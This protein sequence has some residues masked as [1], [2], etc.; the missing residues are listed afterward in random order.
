M[1]RKIRKAIFPVAGM[2]TRF[3]PA[4]KSIP[5][6]MLTVVD[7]P[8]IQYAVDE[9]V[10]AGCDTLIFVTG[11]SKRAIEDYFDSSPE[12]EWELSQK[13]KQVALEAVRSII[14]AHVQCIY[15]RQ[16]MP[17]GLGHAVLCAASLIDKDEAFAVLLPDDL[18]D[19]QG[20]GVLGQM[21]DQWPVDAAGMIAVE[22][23]PEH[24][25]SK[26]GILRPSTSSPSSLI[27]IAS[28]VEKPSP[29]QAPS[30][31]AVVGRYILTQPV[32]QALQHQKPGIGSEIQLTDALS[33]CAGQTHFYGF[34]YEGKR[35][36]CGS[37]AGFHQANVHFWSKNSHPVQV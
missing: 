12:L 20:R 23:V 9:A 18:I 30:N 24:E 33:F 28:L 27:P 37:R 21:V 35:F 1:S 32:M 34:P 26:Y 31:W 13:N 11:R 15:I 22:Q 19:G 4:T 36:D 17:L 2:G 29:A 7:R 25:I 14:P 16:A 8:V 5:K 3:L 6:E 10:Q